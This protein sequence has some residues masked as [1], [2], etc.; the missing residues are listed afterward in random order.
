MDKRTKIQFKGVVKW[1]DKTKGY[2]FLKSVQPLHEVS[3]DEIAEQFS[4]NES[5]IDQLIDKRDKMEDDLF[6]HSNYIIE[7]NNKETSGHYQ[8][9]KY[10]KLEENDEVTFFIKLVKDRE[11]ACYIVL[12]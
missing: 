9:N 6:C 1:F 12:V 8:E 5:E 3:Y 2:G 10:K 11:Q 4:L 7:G